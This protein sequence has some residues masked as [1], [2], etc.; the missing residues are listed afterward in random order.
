M[1]VK[2]INEMPAPQV[3]ERL[4][5]LKKDIREII[6]K[7][8]PICEITDPPYP[9]S[10]MRDRFH[11]AL[12]S[13]LWEYHERFDK[14]EKKH[15][16]FHSYNTLKIESRKIDNV[17]RWYVKFDMELWDKELEEYRK[18]CMEE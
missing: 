10:T 12:H 16:L 3:N 7:R 13:V 6:Q 14:D 17:V 15:F 18:K 4:E 9:S 5:A 8:I 2:P 11:A 1:G